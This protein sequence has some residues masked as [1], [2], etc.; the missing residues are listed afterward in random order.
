MR[1]AV[2]SLPCAAERRK[3]IAAALSPLPYEIFDASPVIPGE[4]PN[5]ACVRS[6]LD[7]LQALGAGEDLL[8][9]EDDADPDMAKLAIFLTDARRALDGGARALLLPGGTLSRSMVAG[10]SAEWI[11]VRWISGTHAALWPAALL[12]AVAGALGDPDLRKAPSMERAWAGLL[13]LAGFEM[14]RHKLDAVKTTGGYSFLRRAVVTPRAMRE[15]QR[16]KGNAGCKS[17]GAPPSN[18]SGC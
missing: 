8:V 12:K 16:L 15:P 4:F 6:H 3:R 2:L 11:H 10:G 5:W 17:F 9:L 14:W 18:R 1:I 7:L 13:G